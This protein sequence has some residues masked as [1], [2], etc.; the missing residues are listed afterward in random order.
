MKQEEI[1]QYGRIVEQIGSGPIVDYVML[2][3]SGTVVDEDGISVPNANVVVNGTAN[4][5]LADFNGKFVLKNVPANSIIDFSYQ[6]VVTKYPAKEVKGKIIINTSNMLGEVIING[7]K[8]KSTSTLLR[9]AS[10]LGLAGL[11]LY[12]LTR[13]KSNT[14]AK[15]SLAAPRKSKKYYVTA[16]I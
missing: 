4:G 1:Y 14:A 6:G 5:V 15:P 2:T 3:L 9:N 12:A 8:P 11:L 16:K 7:T 10:Y 13:K